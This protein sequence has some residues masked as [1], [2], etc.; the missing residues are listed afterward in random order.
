MQ[1]D[2]VE[3]AHDPVGS[4]GQ[5]DRPAHHGLGAVRAGPRQFRDIADELG[6]GQQHRHVLRVTLG[7]CVRVRSDGALRRHQIGR[8]VPCELHRAAGEVDEQVAVH[9]SSWVVGWLT[10]CLFL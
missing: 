9:H 1:A 3:R 5:Q 7:G 4:A 6:T 2:V 8:L 10:I